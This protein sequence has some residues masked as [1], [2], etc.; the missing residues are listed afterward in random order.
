[1]RLNIAHCASKIAS[2]SSRTSTLGK[3]GVAGFGL[4]LGDS[5]LFHPEHCRHESGNG[6]WNCLCSLE[7]WVSWAVVWCRFSEFFRNMPSGFCRL[8]MFHWI[9]VSFSNTKTIDSAVWADWC[10]ACHSTPLHTAKM[11][12]ADWKRCL[13]MRHDTRSGGKTK[14]IAFWISWHLHGESQL[15]YRKNLTWL[16]GRCWRCTSTVSYMSWSAFD[17]ITSDTTQKTRHV[18]THMC[19]CWAAEPRS[20]GWKFADLSHDANSKILF[21]ICSS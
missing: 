1:M 15:G 14:R 5:A 11:A 16:T 18:S 17:S 9:P 12:V 21:A 10:T 2:A 20:L 4:H 19:S 7:A 3:I 13:C 6:G 8:L